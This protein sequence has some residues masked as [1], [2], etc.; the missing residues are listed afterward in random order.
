[1]PADDRYIAMHGKR[2][3]LPLVGRELPFITDEVVEI[4]FGTGA[5][6]VTPSHD[7]NDFKMGLKHNL[8]QV[9]VIDKQGKMTEAAGPDFAGLDRFEARKRVVE[10]LKEQGLLVKVEDYVHKVGHCQRCHT[11]IEPLVSTQWFAVMKQM[12]E[13]A[14]TAVRE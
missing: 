10:K 1:N 7:P 13:A 11:M 5:V 9:V 8:P 3:I 14:I 2:A 4:D 6:K 12:A